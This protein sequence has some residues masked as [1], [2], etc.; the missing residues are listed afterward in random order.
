MPNNVQRFVAGEVGD[1]VVS[2]GGLYTESVTP[3]A[4][5][6]VKASMGRLCKV[7]VTVANGANA[8]LIYDNASAA[9]G[10]VVGIIPASAAVGSIY[11]FQMP[12]LN[13][14]TIAAT[15]GAGTLTISL[16]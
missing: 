8:I 10:T 5:T 16:E 11:D 13:G 12:C 6:V 1:S 3:T 2:T 7:L 9:S 15:V 4:Q 14:I